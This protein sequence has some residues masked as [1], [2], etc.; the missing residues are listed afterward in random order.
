MVVVTTN[1]YDTTTHL[2]WFRKVER[3][4]DRRAQSL[5]EAFCETVSS[6][7][8][9]RPPAVFWFEEADSREA[10][11]AW[12]RNPSRCDQSA[13]P[14]R[15]PCEYFRWRGRPALAFFGYTHRES[16][17]GIMINICR[18]GADL[19][20]TIAEECFHLYQDVLHGAEWRA[21]ANPATIEAEAREFVCSRASDI[22]GFLA[23]WETSR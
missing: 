2:Y 16:V 10:S 19:L 11:Q 12:L 1:N 20:D 4:P 18:S 8:S 9:M 14:L 22:R 23:G 3:H 7:L 15:E 21:T 6:W 13:D 5:A 17:L